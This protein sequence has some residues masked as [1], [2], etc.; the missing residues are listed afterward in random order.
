VIFQDADRQNVSGAKTRHYGLELSLSYAFADNWLLGLD[1]TAARHKYDS[2]IALRGV[3]EDIKGNDI[4]T[5]P[6]FFGSARLGWDFSAW[7]GGRD[8]LAELEWI[9]MDSYYLEPENR[10]EYDGHHLVNLRLSSQLGQRWRGGLRVTN[11]LDV[12]YAER[13]DFG[14]GEYRYFVGEP[15]GVYVEIAYR[16]GAP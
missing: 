8:A 12:D 5:A 7:T 9:Y 3:E 4:D 14:F 13:A 16:F 11:L 15:L 1:A 10:H 6:R 2:S